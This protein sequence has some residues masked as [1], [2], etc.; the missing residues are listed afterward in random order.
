MLDTWTSPRIIAVKYLIPE[1]DL[2]AVATDEDGDLQPVNVGVIEGILDPSNYQHGL[3]W[4]RI[5]AMR[6]VLGTCTSDRPAR[7]MMKIDGQRGTYNVCPETEVYAR[8]RV[9]IDP[10]T[11]PTEATPGQPAVDPA[12]VPA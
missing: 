3:E 9:T 4:H 11:L 7:V 2:V 12:D 6:I 1:R 8:E 5:T 10:W